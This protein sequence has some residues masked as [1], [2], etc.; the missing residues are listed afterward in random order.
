[1]QDKRTAWDWI[2]FAGDGG[3]LRV[4]GGRTLYEAADNNGGAHVRLAR[5]VEEDG[6]LRQINRYVDPH[7]PL[8]FVPEAE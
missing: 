5:L 2:G 7:T 6:R 8:E 4:E 1:M 3:Q